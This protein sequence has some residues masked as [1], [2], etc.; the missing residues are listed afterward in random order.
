VVGGGNTF[1]LLHHC[2]RRGLL[3]LIAERI[4]SGDARYL[5]WS[6]G[7]NIACPTIR[8]TNDMPVI[9]PQGFDA[10]GLVP[11]QINP[12]YTNA[13]PAGHRGETRDQRLAEFTRLEPTVPVLGL[14]EGDWLRV[15]GRELVLGGP[16]A[17]SWFLGAAAPQQVTQGTLALPH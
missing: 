2:R 5:G 9:D 11:F 6:A 16:R 14:P 17:A 4:R 3:P 15:S 13:L 7:T 12:H 10:L 8:T 1:S